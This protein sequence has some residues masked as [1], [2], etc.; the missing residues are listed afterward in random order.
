MVDVANA[1]VKE[2]HVLK[3]II[4]SDAF[5]NKEQWIMI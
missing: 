3:D 1:V 5:F 4:G 2:A